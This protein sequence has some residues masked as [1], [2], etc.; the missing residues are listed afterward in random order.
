MGLLQRCA[1]TYD[2]MSNLVGVYKEGKQVLAPVGFNT[3]KAHIEITIDSN[4][5]FI[6][7]KSFDS[8]EKILIPI[9][10]SSSG[11]S[12]APCPHALCEQIAYLSGADSV[13]YN[14]YIEQL[15]N[16]CNSPHA[17]DKAKAVLNYVKKHSIISDLIS[18]ELVEADDISKSDKNMVTWR[19]LGTSP[20]DA[21]WK[22]RDL[23]NSYSQY[24]QYSISERAKGRCYISGREAVIAEQHL[25][26]VF[27]NNGN[28]KLISANDNTNFTF[29][30]RF[31]D[32]DEAMQISYEMSQKSHNAL[33][34]LIAN[35]SVQRGG[36]AFLCWNPKGKEVPKPLFSFFDNSD[37]RPQPS[38]Y[39]SIL[40]KIL[41][42]YKSSFDSTDLI[43]V[44]S[45]DAATTGRLAVTYYNEFG[46][47]DFFEHMK[48]WDET[49]CFINYG[50]VS[51]PL[52]PQIIKVAFG[53]QRGE[54]E[55]ASLETDDKVFAQQLQ[56]LFSCRIEG[57]FIPTDIMQACVKKAQNLKILTNRNK[58]RVL[59][60]TCAVIKKYKYDYFKEDISMALEKEREDRSYQYGRL[61]A[62]LEKIELD[63]YNGD[64]ARDTNAMRLQS[65]FVK[66]PAYATQIIM[67]RLKSAYYPKLSYGLKVY[68]EKLIGEIM[69]MIS[70][71]GEEDYNK[72][73][74]E[75][76]LLG[77]YLQ[78]NDFYKKN[79]DN[80]DMEENDNE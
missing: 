32:S 69:E 28:A 53:T 75:T 62:V 48:F 79:N 41:S 78:K 61:L 15:E 47:D 80:N 60:T 7:A 44:A 23:M 43:I 63:T 40:S 34:W 73:L 30:G 45:F 38:N 3:A 12:I 2:N 20:P 21:V 55:N 52:L 25:K 18:F 27:S 1:E 58:N 65:V 6:S 42:G 13:K 57:S 49:C 76:Y 9:T 4:G 29:R 19:V 72:S 54:A 26:G 50:Y 67:D 70:N 24:Y 22:D 64:G 39:K 14:L 8:D 11:R 46:A 17:N 59:F 51:S 5:N 66:R 74:G 37:E 77:Y 36:R 31:L 16:W 68:Y 33:K 35:D 56:R 10:E 71:C